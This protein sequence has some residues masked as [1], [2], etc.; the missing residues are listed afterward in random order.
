MFRFC[1]NAQSL[2]VTNYGAIGDATNIVVGT[3]SNSTIVISSFILPQS[4]AGQIIEVFGAGQWLHLSNNTAYPVAVTNQDMIG[5]IISISGTSITTSFTNGWTTNAYCVIGTNNQTAFQNCI[6]A[7]QNMATNGG[8]SIN[9]PNGKYLVIGSLALSPSTPITQFQNDGA[10][11]V[12]SGGITFNGESTNATLIGCGAGMNHPYNNNVVYGSY[13][14]WNPYRGTLIYLNG[15]TNS[16]YPLVFQNI[17]FDGGMTNGLQSYS[18][19]TPIEGNGEGWDT[20]HDAICQNLA[21]LQQVQLLLITNCNFQHYRGEILK[22]Q[23]G[24]NGGTNTVVRIESDSFYD[25]NASANNMYYGQYINGCTFNNL[26]KTAEYNQS[27]A[28][29]SLTYTNC[30]TTNIVSANITLLASAGTISSNSVTIAN[31]TIAIPTGNIGIQ[32]SPAQNVAIN[33]NRFYGTANAISIQAGGRQGGLYTS[34]VVINLNDFGAALSPIQVLDNQPVYNIKAT[35][36]I[37]SATYQFFYSA[38]EIYDVILSGN[39]SPGWLDNSFGV[40][41]L[42]LTNNNFGPLNGQGTGEF[43]YAGITNFMTYGKGRYHLITVAQPTTG[44]ILSSSMQVPLNAQMWLTNIGGNPVVIF[45]GTT[46]NFIKSINNN[47]FGMFTYDGANWQTNGYAPSNISPQAIM[48]G[49]T[50]TGT[51][52]YP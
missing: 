13:G 49:A 16:Q 35:N 2:N 23:T 24:D 4:R 33:G 5:T 51:I 42:D 40:Y 14:H 41:P 18:Y 20:S 11:S 7:G 15:A 34:N 3:V 39:T 17:T 38:S 36:N 46:A 43:D 32:I 22:N 30:V 19:F 10:L 37:G 28:T 8:V 47:S 45:N 6:N 27:L 1:A 48:S 52:S 25:A 21:G 29:S 26:V 44:Y 9:I 31:S 50:F 12:T